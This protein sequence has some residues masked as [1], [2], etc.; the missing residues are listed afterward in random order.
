MALAPGRAG[1]CAN[2]GPAK[3]RSALRQ[4]RPRAP[5]QPFRNVEPRAPGPA[6]R[7]VAMRRP[8][9]DDG[10]GRRSADAAPSLPDRRDRPTDRAGWRN[11]PRH[12][13]GPM[14][15]DADRPPAPAPEDDTIAGAEAI[16]DTIATGAM[17]QAIAECRQLLEAAG[18]RY[19][20]VTPAALGYS[21]VEGVAA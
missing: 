10:P 7:P 9:V 21:V 4:P 5:F 6:R 14:T 8:P 13:A 19:V 15:F 12:R 16:L 1:V 17:S 20:G 11:P 18:F 2:A 3:A